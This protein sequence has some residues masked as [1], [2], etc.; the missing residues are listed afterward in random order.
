[1]KCELF[2]SYEMKENFKLI[3]KHISKKNKSCRIICDDMSIH[4]KIKD[5]GYNAFLWSEIVPNDGPIAERAY[6]DAKNL[7]EKYLQI[8]N[9][10]K[11]KDIEIFK[12]FDYSLLMQLTILMKAKIIL[13]EKIDTIFIFSSFF[14]VYFLVLDYAKKLGYQHDNMIGLLKNHE[15]KYLDFQNFKYMKQYKKEFSQ[16]RL[17]I[18][19]QSISSDKSFLKDFEFY[20]KVG[21]RMFAHVIRSLPYKLLKSS[22]KNSIAR[23]LKRIENKISFD[24]SIVSAFF[25]TTSREDLY[26]KPWYPVFKK[27][28]K[29]NL[30]YVIL[31]SDIATSIILSKEKIPFINLFDEINFLQN[32]LSHNDIWFDI[33]N[34]ILNIIKENN[35]IS[36]V[37]ELSNYFVNQS[38]KTTAILMVCEYIFA[39]LKLKSTIALADGEMLENIA[40]QISKKYEIPNFSLLPVAIFPQPLLADWFHAEKIFVHGK[41]GI[42]CLTSLGYK[43]SKLITTGNPRYDYIKNINIKNS[44]LKL[45]KEADIESL[46]KLVVVAMG[47]YHKNDEEWMSKLIKFC[48]KNNLEIIIKIHPTY[49]RYAQKDILNLTKIKLECQKQKFLVTYDMDITSLLSAADLVITDY[50]SVGLETIYLEKP[51]IT[52]NFVKEDLDYVIRYHDYGASIYCEDY[53]ELEKTIMEVFNSSIHQKPLEA[54]RQ[55]FIDRFNFKNDGKASERIFKILCNQNINH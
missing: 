53:L 40:I 8:F 31:T 55:K 38:L 43:Q 34:K 35:D 47:R 16:K 1:M 5:E 19:V 36:G 51:L 26:L 44:K 25:V 7:Q 12:G 11:F 6:H 32:E 9:K 30:D 28:K 27:F 10:I 15:I 4:K 33:K 49:K 45:E 52:V 21:I 29:E 20:F 3:Q 50:S 24:D 14:D 48:N 54:G 41:D 2:F 39:K 42:D 46:K 22:K 23:I 37:K 17:K 13:E 18:F